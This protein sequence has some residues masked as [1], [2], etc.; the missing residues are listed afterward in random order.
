MLKNKKLFSLIIALCLI[1]GGVSVKTNATSL[2][3]SEIAESSYS[4]GNEA[5]VKNQM[6]EI[7]NESSEINDEFNNTVNEISTKQDDIYNSSESNSEETIINSEDISSEA[8]EITSSNEESLSSEINSDEINEE[9]IAF[10]EPVQTA[11]NAPMAYA[12]TPRVNILVS[13]N[14]ISSPRAFELLGLDKNV[15]YPFIVALKKDNNNGT[16]SSYGR[17][18][19]K[20]SYNT[21][22]RASLNFSSL[23][24]G[25]YILTEEE[26][27]AY[28]NFVDMVATNSLQGVTFSKVNNEY[29]IVISNTASSG[30]LNVQVRNELEARDEPNIKIKFTRKI[31]AS[32][33]DWDRLLL[34]SQ[35]NYSFRVKV[36]NNQNNIE[37]LGINDNDGFS[38][39]NIGIGKYY[40]E[41]YDYNLFKFSNLE[42]SNAI[43]G[44]T[45]TKQGN[46]YLLTIGNQII[47]DTTININENLT[48]K[49]QR[50]YEDSSY[51]TCYLKYN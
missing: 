8:S 3:N 1:L 49:E 35:E 30:T 7:D 26:M 34:N 39:N 18:T 36:K 32:N 2:I 4:E 6:L 16:Y 37:I 42:L 38:I 46:G 5:N 51:K 10:P 21:N 23:S 19:I 41:A 44:I 12:T 9:D 50:F 15:S 17:G 40:I 20:G 31:N 25:T 14:I 24:P 47:T 29:R 27:P 11:I 45:L 22:K 33:D 43:N 13:K 28:F 48:L